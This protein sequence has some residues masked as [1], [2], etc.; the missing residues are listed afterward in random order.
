MH[1][2]AEEVR[3]FV[4]NGIDQSVNDE[5]TRP[6]DREFLSDFRLMITMLFNQLENQ[7]DEGENFEQTMWDI[8]QQSFSVGFLINTDSRQAEALKSALME[9]SREK[10]LLARNDRMEKL[11]A[12]ILQVQPDISLLRAGD[13]Y[14]SQIEERVISILAKADKDDK[15]P[16]RRTIVGAISAIKKAG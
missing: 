9:R 4:I 8:I 15:W 14:V 2:R 3:S 10:V 5:R 6:S 7:I 11:K 13:K 1:S 16:S 12:A